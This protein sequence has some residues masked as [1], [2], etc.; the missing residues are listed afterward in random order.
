MYRGE[1]DDVLVLDALR[2]LVE[3]RRQVELEDAPAALEIRGMQLP[4]PPGF[5][6]GGLARMEEGICARSSRGSMPQ[7]L[8]QR[9]DGALSRG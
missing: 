8:V 7:R 4:E 6:R 1:A 2:N 5:Q 3:E 9:L